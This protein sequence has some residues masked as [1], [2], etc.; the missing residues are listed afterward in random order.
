[1]PGP[2]YRDLMPEAERILGNRVRTPEISLLMWDDLAALPKAI[3]LVDGVL[4]RDSIACLWG[5]SRSFK[6]F[7]A[8][9]LGLHIATGRPW[10]GRSTQ[11]GYVVY[12]VGEGATGFQKRAYAAAD[13]L[14]MVSPDFAV[15]PRAYD[16]TDSCTVGALCRRLG[17]LQ[18]AAIFVDTYFRY[19]PGRDHNKQVDHSLVMAGLDRLRQ[20]FAAL[21][22]PLDHGTKDPGDVRGPGGTV[23]KFAGYDTVLMLERK[24]KSSTATLTMQKQ[25]DAE[26]L[27]PLEITFVEHCGSLVVGSDGSVWEED[28]RRQDIGETGL[29]LRGSAESALA[30]LAGIS[31]DDGETM[32]WSKWRDAARL[33]KPTFN[34]ARKH[35]VERNLVEKVNRQYRLTSTGRDRFLRSRGLKVV[36]PDQEETGHGGNTG[37]T[38]LRGETVRPDP[39]PSGTEV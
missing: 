29:A 8:I 9:H 37:F 31:T 19:A 15:V 1:M 10:F 35:L 3:W 34:A 39:D 7:L 12:L 14:G 27:G 33:A 23:H 6:T 32:S 13:V 25:K 2:N 18:P 16:I 26:E 4:Q 28:A 30:G 36:S 20:E 17:D 22:M 38:P 24:G 11:P 5:A 21:I